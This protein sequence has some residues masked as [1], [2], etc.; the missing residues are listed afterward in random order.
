MG[1]A[2][3]VW[4]PSFA[5]PWYLGAFTTAPT[6]DNLGVTLSASHKGYIYYNTTSEDSWIYT[7]SAWILLSSSAASNAVDVAISDAGGNYSAVNV[8]AALAEL[9]S[10]SPGEG[11]SI[12]GIEDSGSI[13][14]AATNVEAALQELGSNS[15]SEGASIIGIQDSGTF[16]ADSNVEAAL[17]QIG[18][19]FTPFARSKLIIPPDLSINC[20]LDYFILVG[21]AR[22]IVAA[23]NHLRAI[24]TS[25]PL[26]IDITLSGAGGLDTGAEAASTWY[27][28]WAI[29]NP[30]T[31]TISG[32]LSTSSSNP[33][34][35]AGYSYKALLGAVYNDS[36][37]NFLRFN[38]VGK[39]VAIEDDVIVAGTATVPT[40]LNL[41][42]P[43]DFIDFS[44]V[45]IAEVLG[46]ITVGNATGG[47]A[48]C[49]AELYTYD[50]GANIK[51]RTI[52]GGYGATA[53]DV[54]SGT[55]RLVPAPYSGFECYYNLS[56]ANMTA[57][58]VMTGWNYI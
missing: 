18:S 53:G 48:Y 51:G 34:M 56:G 40:G 9:A 41:N 47:N 2:A 42:L 38:Q 54:A 50:G 26:T 57:S 30:S 3:N 33:T 58:I 15:T 4:T 10:V 24:T 11:A 21:Y 16:F 43:S 12:I 29:Y 35:P 22:F 32:M 6:T 39:S 45:D 13:F 25:Y 20:S 7:G 55:F 36:G 19:V 28:I 46:Y 8:E 23:G 17:A 37:S 31:D 49:E 27:Y 1:D 5:G 14:N 44:D 52:V